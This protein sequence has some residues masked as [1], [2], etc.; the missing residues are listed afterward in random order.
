MISVLLPHV[1]FLKDTS[2]TSE[3]T[4]ENN[5]AITTLMCRL[6]KKSFIRPQR[7]TDE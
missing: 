4:E 5:I 7:A 2:T 6:K 3:I 1:F